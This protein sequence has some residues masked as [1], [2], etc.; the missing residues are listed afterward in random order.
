MPQPHSNEANIDNWHRRYANSL[1]LHDKRAEVLLFSEVCAIRE[2]VATQNMCMPLGCSV[3]MNG[4][5]TYMK[6]KH[7]MLLCDYINESF[8]FFL[9]MM[10]ALNLRNSRAKTLIMRD[11]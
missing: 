11:K 1:R 5:V 2:M 4:H 7:S 6:I 9:L 8:S 3:Q 10:W